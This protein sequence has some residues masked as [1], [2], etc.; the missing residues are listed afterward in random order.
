MVN[1][2]SIVI[3]DRALKSNAETQ[4]IPLVYAL[5]CH[6]ELLKITER[7]SFKEAKQELYDAHVGIDV[8]N[9]DEVITSQVLKKNAKKFISDIQKIKFLQ[10]EC[11][12]MPEVNEIDQLSLTDQIHIILLAHGFSKCI[13]LDD[14]FF[15]I[16][17]AGNLLYKVY[18]EYY[19]HRAKISNIKDDIRSIFYNLIGQEG[20]YFWGIN[21][22]KS[23]LDEKMLIHFFMQMDKEENKYKP[24]K[25]FTYFCRDV[26][27]GDV[28]YNVINKNLI[29]GSNEI[30]IGVKDFVIKS[31][32]F[33]CV[34]DSHNIENIVGIINILNTKGEIE[35]QKVS[36]GYCNECKVYF[37]MQSTYQQLIKKGI[38]LCK[39]VD[40]KSFLAGDYRHG[41]N[42]A[43]ESILKQ[44]GYNVSQRD[45]LSESD[46]Q[47]NLSALID[48]GIISK[49]E[50]ISY[51]DFFI[52]Q[53]SG[54]DNM[55]LAVEK[56]KKARVFIE[57]YKINNCK[58]VEIQT[59]HNR[60]R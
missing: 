29:N 15:K 6:K 49:A 25:S 9:C 2:D 22:K 12:K 48:T 36:A 11:A 20:K 39:I 1:I 40:Y 54:L 23:N 46:R 43:K 52:R 38:L 55:I 37:I 59:I 44:Y 56:W 33:Q 4:V 31:N 8:M 41:F 34:H 42:L 45:G 58:K 30:V 21:I 13:V 19:S 35:Q 10:Q 27:Y 24:G 53:K 50:V 32:V 28:E 3:R 16:T 47:N 5:V 14:R 26:L 60:R 51:L 18:K 17:N 57:N 7:W